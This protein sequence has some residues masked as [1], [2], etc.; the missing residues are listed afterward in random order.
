MEQNGGL[1]RFQRPEQLPEGPVPAEH[2]PVHSLYRIEAGIRLAVQQPVDVRRG[3]AHL[4]AVLIAQ[5]AQ[6]H[7]PGPVRHIIR[8]GCRLLGAPQ[9]QDQ[10]QTQAVQPGTVLRTHQPGRGDATVDLPPADMFAFVRLVAAQLPEVRAPHKGQRHAGFLAGLRRGRVYR[11]LYTAD[12]RPPR[13]WG[14]TAPS[15]AAIR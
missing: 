2:P 14:A 4:L 15:S 12:G 11:A 1:P 3:K 6:A 7:Q 8:Q 10:P 9:V 5:T 13:P